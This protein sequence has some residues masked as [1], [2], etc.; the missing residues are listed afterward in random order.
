V[1]TLATD[2]DILIDRLERMTMEINEIRRA[3]IP[4]V[5][6]GTPLAPFAVPIRRGS[7]IIDP[8][9][10]E[11]YF[12]TVRGGLNVARQIPAATK[13]VAKKARTKRQKAN[14]KLQSKAFAEANKA[15]RTVK[16]TLRKGRTQADVARRAQ[17]LLRRMKKK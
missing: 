17:K 3:I 6:K 10:T 5:T 15:L 12:D 9:L 11:T 2:L 8:V 14:D 7:E 16:G 1:S 13:T 4:V